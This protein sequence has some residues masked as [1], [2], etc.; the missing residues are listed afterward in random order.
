M[1]VTSIWGQLKLAAGAG[2]LN[3]LEARLAYAQNIYFVGSNAPSFVQ[4]QSTIAAALAALIPGDVLVLG[5]QEFQEAGLVLPASATDVTIIGMG[6]RGACFNEPQVTTDEGLQILADG[7]AIVNVGL[8]KGATGD[9]ALSVGSN[10]VSPDRFRAYGCKIEGDGVAAKLWGAGDVLIDDC[11]FCWCGTGIQ[12][13]ANGIGFNTQIYIRRSRF[14][15]CV[16]ACIAHS[17]ASQVV[18]GLN[19]EDCSFEEDEAGTAPTDFIL[20]SDNGNTGVI[21]GNRFATPTNAT[22]VLTIGTGILWVANA[23]EAGWST[24]RP[25]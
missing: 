24:A 7:C 4:Q 1:S 3:G 23:T 2:I 9:F 22:G 5:P 10:T 15:D 14:H 16:D 11:E 18:N 25:S 12:L 8:A 6:P 20:L 21:H 19:L 17:A 13:A